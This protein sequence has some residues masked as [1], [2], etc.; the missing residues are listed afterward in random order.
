MVGRTSA[1]DWSGGLMLW[2]REGVITSK[3]NTRKW[4]LNL[5][6]YDSNCTLWTGLVYDKEEGLNPLRGGVK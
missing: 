4:E 6:K 1:G 2:W 5:T 3:T